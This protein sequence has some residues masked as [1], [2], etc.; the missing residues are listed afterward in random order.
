MRTRL[1]LGPALLAAIVATVTAAA[2]IL[3]PVDL[4]V[5]DA[6]LRW[7][8]KHPARNVALV[9]ID[10]ESLRRA[11]AWPWSR[12]LLARL[13]DRVNESGARGVVL[14][15]LL[16]EGREGDEDLSAALSRRPSVLATGID[17]REGWLLP[18][19]ALR[20]GVT[21]AHVSF[22][23]DRDGVV[24]RYLATKQLSSRSLPAMAMAGARLADPH[25]PLPVGATLRPGFQSQRPPSVSAVSLLDGPVD[26][27]RLAGRVVFVGATAAGIGD[28]FVSPVSAG[29]APEPGVLIQAAACEATITGDLLRQVPPLFAGLLA[30]V[31]VLLALAA[32]NRPVSLLVAPLPLVVGIL[33]LLVS[34]LELPAVT[35]AA[36]S[37]AVTAGLALAGAARQRRETIQAARRVR[38]LTALAKTLEEGRREDL[39]VRRVVAHELRTP[40]TSVRG[41][42]QL[43]SDFDLSEEERR[44]VAGMVVAETSRLSGMVEAL[45]DL[46]RMKLRDFSEHSQR[47]DLSRLVEERAS[48][49]GSGSDRDFRVSVAPRVEVRGDPALLGRVLDNLAGNAL[50]FSPEGT[51]V[52]IRLRVEE[53]RAVVEVADSGPGVPPEER[54]RIFRRFARGRTV[55]PVPGLGLG[56]AL[57]SEAAAWH[58]G[59][60]DVE[61]NP[62]GGSVFRVSL[63]LSLSGARHERK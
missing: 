10:E 37:T 29:G 21:L 15:L 28:R 61:E 45:L 33:L 17:D 8:P 22:E 59:S 7:R 6:V 12:V 51:P 25:R 46:E 16:P 50:K 40:L 26:P 34:D 42:A 57:V 23:A 52:G 5:R 32:G 1:G 49:L 63:P 56:L 18:A 55:S 30:G 2:R 53:D 3:F 44:R 39:E 58:G 54:G 38:E 35:T 60:A 43:L 31:T 13:L 14:D 4:F 11:G 47:V 9:V 24:Q 62:G 41:L 20:R 19:E 48:V 36:S 27:G